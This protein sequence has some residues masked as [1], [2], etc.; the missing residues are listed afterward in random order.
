MFQQGSPQ[1]FS[2]SSLCRYA[3]RKPTH[4]SI[5]CANPIRR[6]AQAPRSRHPFSRLPHIGEPAVTHC[7][8]GSGFHG[9]V[10]AVSIEQHSLWSP[11][12]GPS[13]TLLPPLLVH[14]ISPHLLTR[15]GPLCL[16][17]SLVTEE[18]GFTKAICSLAA[19]IESLRISG[20]DTKP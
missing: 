14:P 13:W 6:A 3:S 10:L 2:T 12:A 11:C 16:W 20:Q 15:R 17:A 9:H 19:P 5:V 18:E 4:E 8:D 7:L 1:A